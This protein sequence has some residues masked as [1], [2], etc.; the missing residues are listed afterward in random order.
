M[1]RVSSSGSNAR[2]AEDEGIVAAPSTAL[3]PGVKLIRLWKGITH[4]VVVTDGGFVW[5][6]ETYKSLSVIA[7]KITGTS[8]SG[9]VFY[10]L[11]KTKAPRAWTPEAD[12]GIQTHG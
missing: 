3:R 11:K 1:F 4:H 5:H 6:E 9:P 2:A 12:T 8:W 10:G 7:R